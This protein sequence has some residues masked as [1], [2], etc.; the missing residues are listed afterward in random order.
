M[1]TWTENADG[2]IVGM[3]INLIGSDIESDSKRNREMAYLKNIDN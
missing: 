2:R 3:F 1:E